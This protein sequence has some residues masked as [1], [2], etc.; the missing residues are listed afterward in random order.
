MK[1]PLGGLLG[2]SFSTASLHLNKPPSYGVP[3]GPS[4]SAWMS[5]AS[6]SFLII[7]TPIFY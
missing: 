7:F 6:F 2:K 4:I 3:T 5:V 1:N